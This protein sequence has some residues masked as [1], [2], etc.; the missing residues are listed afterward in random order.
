MIERPITIDRTSAL[1]INKRSDSDLSSSPYYW[2]PVTS[3]DGYYGDEI[4]YE[5]HPIAGA[6]GERSSTPLKSGK[7][8]VLTGE[9]RA[10]NLRLLRGAEEVLQEALWSGAKFNLL[11]HTWKSYAEGGYTDSSNRLYFKV[12]VNQPLVIVDQITSHEYKQN[13]TVGLRADDP[14]IYEESDDSTYHSWQS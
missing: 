4:R 10:L 13:W 9:I 14:R 3:V 2:I 11:F 6:D 8:L 5:S 12:R 1:T 7:Q